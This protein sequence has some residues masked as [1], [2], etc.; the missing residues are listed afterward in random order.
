MCPGAFASVTRVDFKTLDRLAIRPL[1]VYGSKDEIVRLLQ[2]IGAVDENGWVILVLPTYLLFFNLTFRARALLN[3]PDIDGSQSGLSSGLYV[4]RANAR[5]NCSDERHYVIYWPEDTTW[6]DSA[7][8]SVCRNRAAFMRW[9]SLDSPFFSLSQRTQNRYLTKMCDQVIVLLSPEYSASIVWDSDEN[10]SESVDI[11]TDN[12][13]R[14]FT[15]EVSKRN[16]QE[17][18]AVVRPGFQVSILFVV[19][20]LFLICQRCISV[21]F[22]VI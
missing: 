18:S 4:V 3:Q 9:A 21:T 17:E 6:N 11:D 8:P 10:G 12:T 1:G 16:E 15:F 22:R 5:T 13:D 19:E 2:S 20:N 7:A 14:M